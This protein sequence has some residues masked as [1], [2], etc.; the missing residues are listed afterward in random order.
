MDHKLHDAPQAQP[1]QD[2]AQ[3]ALDAADLGTW[4]VDLRTQ[5]WT[6]RSPRHDELFG[7]PG[8]QAQ[9]NLATAERHVL[10]E[11]RPALRNLF[12]HAREAGRLRLELRVRWPDGATRWIELR[13]SR[14]NDP[15]GGTERLSGVIGEIT[16]RRAPALRAQRAQL[17]EDV[18]AKAPSFLH[19]LQGPDH[20][21]E[22]ANEAYYRLVGHRDL[23]G[24][25][26]FEALPEAAHEGFQD[27]LARV[28]ETGEPFVGH[29]LGVTLARTPGA[30]VEHRIIDLVYQALAEP[31]G[32]RTRVLGHGV[33][34]TEH[35][36][37]RR[38]AEAALATSLQRFQLLA[39]ALERL[40]AA[41]TREQLLQVVLESARS[42]CGADG[43]S[44]VLREQQQCF[45]AG[46]DSPRG[47]LWAG[48]RFCVNDCV[49]GWAMLQSQTIVIPD[50][51]ADPR[52]PRE[53][54]APTFVR[55]MVVV[56]V[57]ATEP[58]A[59][60]G[61]YWAQVHTPGAEELALLQ[62]LARVAGAALE[63]RQA[64]QQRLQGEERLRLALDVA[65]MD[66]FE[67][68]PGTGQVRRSGSL[69][70]ELGLAAQGPATQ[71]FD[72]LHPQ[73][74]AALQAKL[75]ALTPERPVHIAEYRYRSTHGSWR[76][77]MD[78]ARMSFTADGQPLRLVGV[79]M[80]ITERKQAQ[81]ELRS[82]NATLETRVAQ[83]TAELA[84]ARDAAEAANRA[85]SA[86]LANMSHEIRTPMNAILGLTHLLS[87]EET[88]PR[89][90]QQLGRIDTAARHLLTV[91]NDIL[92]ISRIDAGKLQLEERDFDLP[93]LLEQVRSMVGEG[94]AAKGLRLQVDVD[95]APR[96]LRGDDTRLR[97]ALLNYA[98][99]AVK[100]TEAGTVTLRA[101]QLEQRAGDWLLVRF[102][103]EDT[104]AGV[105]PHQVP[106]LFQAFEQADTSTTRKHGGTGL[107]LAI[108][109]RLAELMGGSAGMQ[110][111][112][113]GGSAF[114]FTA[115]LGRGAEMPLRDEA[116]PARADAQLRQRHAGARVLVAEDNVVNR[117]VAAALLQAVELQVDFAENGQDAIDKARQHGY[118]LV[119]MDVHMPLLD[120]LEAT[121]TLRA[122]PDL[123]RLPILAMTANAFDED[124]AACLAA[125]MN[126]F[127]AKP[128]EPLT[129]YATLL[130]WLDRGEAG[131]NRPAR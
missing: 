131:V 49:S 9:W 120:G 21:F 89:Q 76:W 79:S 124:R 63:L 95:Q 18:F 81:D 64:V 65:H 121:R 100:F 62:T 27:L 57:G 70:V 109:R 31:D 14:T 118:A 24:R 123:Q 55:G 46:E 54:Y 128:V 72:Q 60:L 101:R 5:T 80:D 32:S 12:R 13:G 39:Q 92:D 96:R 45:Y 117:E 6:H 102:E 44:L 59:A 84:A 88:S 1:S 15:A 85:K 99:N 86:F 71:F 23:I 38:Q 56:P 91:I 10:E 129:L 110:P 105:E 16:E 77:L 94:A 7:Y 119:L 112:E 75:Q 26:A 114:W 48:Q 25:P 126:D 107:G 67:Y 93:A 36:Q 73:D 30:P 33:D 17:L 3:R 37:R 122:L 52:V 29:E 35:V 51:R 127:V 43:V 22:L 34:V 125:G 19:V 83:R 74:R 68:E 104:G 47:P 113:G 90:A 50:V 42:L 78:H 40:V 11:D 41:T 97:Q 111:H 103:V 98:S 87:R 115:R 20:V 2:Q 58:A 28:L 82:L 66:A 69:H 130:Q 4:E 61:A 8:R 108:T 53:P 106:R 116:R